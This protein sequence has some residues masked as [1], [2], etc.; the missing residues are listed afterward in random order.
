MRLTMTA[1]LPQQP[2]S[3]GEARH[4]LAVLLSLTTAEEQAR[5]HLAVLLTE[6]CANVVRHGD[7]GTTLDLH[8]AIEAGTCVLEVGNRGRVPNGGRLPTRLPDPAQTN[9]RGLPLI[10]ALSDSA[11]FVPTTS[12]YVL[13]RMAM[14][15][16][17]HS[18]VRAGEPSGP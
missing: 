6:A 14:R 1:S 16:Q 5:D 13:L 9:G 12:G 8:I 3:I 4:I 18:H 11:Q 17:A 10:A 7:A 2:S 15:L